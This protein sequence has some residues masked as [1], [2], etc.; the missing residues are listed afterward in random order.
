MTE[1]KGSLVDTPLAIEIPIFQPVL[2]MAQVWETV[3]QKPLLSSCSMFRYQFGLLIHCN[4]STEI[5][6]V[7]VLL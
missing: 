6:N 4:I 7:V 2:C 3:T 5:P 1:K